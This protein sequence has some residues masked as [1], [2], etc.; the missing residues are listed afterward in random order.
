MEKLTTFYQM[1]YDTPI[2]KLVR[3]IVGLDRQAA[4]ESFSFLIPEENLNLNRYSL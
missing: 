4:K 3:Q 2:T 1:R